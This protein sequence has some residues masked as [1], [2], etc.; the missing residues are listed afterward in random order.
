MPN[1]IL[2]E[3]VL[4]SERVNAL[5]PRA[6]LFYRRLMS[7]VDDFGRMELPPG[8]LRAR[9]YPLQLDK[10]SE[11][12]IAEM[13]IE[14]S[15]DSVLVKV[16]EV[17]GKKFL[18]IN[19]FGQRERLSRCPSPESAAFGGVSPR[20]AA[21]ASTPT[22]TTP[23]T[24]EV[25][26]EENQEAKS[27]PSVEASIAGDPHLQELLGMFLALGRGLSAGDLAVCE[28]AWFVLPMP[29]QI[30]ALSHARD[31]L[32]EWRT[33]QT[34]MIPQPWNFLREKHWDRATPR[35]LQQ[36]RAPTKREEATD[37]AAQ[38]FMEGS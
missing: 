4:T 22:P 37:R 24:F 26:S 28:A 21:R 9:C 8:L 16:Y 6:E 1:R 25:I 35:L 30:K 7:V 31:S 38:R 20:Y 11:Y 14:C 23:L 17:N 27:A 34:K 36:T 10:Y 19:N 29:E 18:Q 2:R 33:R 5:S 3:G 13:L 15:A 32:A 12:D